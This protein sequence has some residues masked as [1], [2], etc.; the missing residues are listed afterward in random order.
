MITMENIIFKITVKSLKMITVLALSI[1]MCLVIF[2]IALIIISPGKPKPFL[3]ETGKMIIGSVS[4][5]CFVEINGTRQGMFISGVDST[6]PVLL[7]VHGGPGVPEYVISRNYP[8]VLEKYFTVCWWDQ[9]GAGLSYSSDIPLETL[10]FDQFILDA[11][12]VTN[13]LR[14]R[15]NK[16]KI[17]LM[18]HSGGTVFAIQLAAKYPELYHAYLA[19][20]QI[21]NQ[22]E[23]EKL[24]YNY[25]VEQFAKAGDKKML[26]RFERYTVDCIN[27]P[28]YY[29]MRDAPM[30]KL[31]IGTTHKMHS[32]ITGVFIP[33]NMASEYTLSEKINFWRGKVMNTNQANLWAKLVATDIPSMIKKLELPVYFFNGYYD[34]TT[35]CT[36]AKA[37]FDKL[38]APLK[39]FYTFE[40]SAHSPIFEE[41]ELMQEILLNDVLKGRNFLDDNN[42]DVWYSS[43]KIK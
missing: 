42:K 15:Y 10:N 38:N 36:L 43:S 3:D 34:Y 9:R 30:H 21:T 32:V 29:V 25:M 41:P 31:G 37:Y 13:Y 17:Y 26:K 5:K 8:I 22:Q 24:A 7:F 4:E 27:T 18:A 1:L 23:S 40:N 20:S 19:V 35:S 39:A 11:K 33:V 16:D 14:K 2:T 28:S 6:K 12:E